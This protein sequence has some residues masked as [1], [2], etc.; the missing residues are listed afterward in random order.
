MQKILLALVALLMLCSVAVGLLLRSEIVEEPALKGELIRDSMEW[1]GMARSYTLYL[2]HWLNAQAAL[3]F[4]LHGSTGDAQRARMSFAY[5]FERLAARGFIAVF[6]EGFAGHWNDCRKAATYKA[7]TQQVDDVG[8]L[9]ALRSRLLD[10]FAADPQRTFITGISNGGQ[11]AYRMALEAPGTFRAHAAVIASLPAPENMDCR[12][13]DEAVSMLVMN[14]TADPMNPYE[15]GEVAWYGLL[16]SR[17]RVLS[18]NDTVSYWRKLAGLDK[19]A[20]QRVTYDEADDSG[21][22]EVS[23]WQSEQG[24]VIEQFDIVGGG[25]TVPHPQQSVPRLLGPTSHDISAAAEIWRF[26][27]EHGSY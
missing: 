19:T 15:G 13:A 1:Q 17:G 8:F 16:G 22:V 14:G 21:R 12:T 10:E 20:P 18:T 23:R 5:D 9:N 3:V 7:N 25:H 6:P 27:D 4:V 11:M 2:P 26:F 24:I